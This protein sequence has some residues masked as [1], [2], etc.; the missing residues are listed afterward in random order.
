[1]SQQLAVLGLS[2]LGSLGTGALVG[3]TSAF[4]LEGDWG[5]ESLDFGCDGLGLLALLLD[6][7]TD[8]VLGDWV[9]LLEGEELADVVGALGTE[10]TGDLLVGQTLDLALSLFDDGQVQD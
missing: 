7:A 5:D 1:L 4:A 8:D 2:L 3:H 9:R 10:T 6:G